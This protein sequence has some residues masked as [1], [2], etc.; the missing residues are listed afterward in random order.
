MRFTICRVSN[1]A[2]LLVVFAVF[3]SCTQVMS[4]QPR[5]DPLQA[6]DFFSNGS[7]A[8]P[9]PIGVI[10]HDAAPM[11]EGRDTG[12]INGKPVDRF[13]FPLD[14]AVM[15]RG[16]QRYNIYCAPCH[17]YIGTG[18]GMA[19]IR[20]FQRKPPSFHSEELRPAPPGRFFDVITNGFGAMPSYANQIPVHDR[21]AIIAYV[22]ALQLSQAG[23]LDSVPA[24]ERSRLQTEKER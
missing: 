19:V 8:R 3:T 10:A 4:D 22:R 14:Q 1:C 6:S 21:W 15:L 9:L 12:M 16:R 23:T 20:G 7:S 2:L 5:Y 11:D 24:N 13:P 17:D 18:N